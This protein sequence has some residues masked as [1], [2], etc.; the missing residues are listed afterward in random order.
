[1]RTKT[2]SITLLFVL[3]IITYPSA[4]DMSRITTNRDRLFRVTSP[5]WTQTG[6]PGGGYINDIA[7]D[8]DKPSLIYAV[9][10]DEG[11]YKSSDGG[12]SWNL[13]TFTD[14]V[15][16]PIQNLEM[17]PQ[18]P[19]TLF[20]SSNNDLLK[21]LDGGLSWTSIFNGFDDC[22]RYAK[23]I[24]MNPL[25][26]AILYVGTGSHCRNSVGGTVYVTYDGGTSF[27][28]IG[29]NINAPAGSIVES[30]GAAGNG[31]NICRYQ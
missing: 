4:Q 24:E 1:M 13:I 20:C 8:P 14:S 19:S 25:N 12:E 10:S 7:I 2:L 6:G 29:R 23:I 3:V 17:D 21:S 9:G 16:E 5:E 31:K 30:L 26:S 15:G 18:N 27:D 11:I 28:N 22:T